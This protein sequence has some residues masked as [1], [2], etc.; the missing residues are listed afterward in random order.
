MTPR[1]ARE[2]RSD[3]AAL[4]AYAARLTQQRRRLASDQRAALLRLG[5]HRHEHDARSALD[6]GDVRCLV[7]AGVL[8]PSG[9]DLD[10]R[11]TITRRAQQ[12]AAL[13]SLIAYTE[14]QARLADHK[15][16][17]TKSA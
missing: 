13:D 16:A 6:A 7:D 4:D 3:G 8:A 14:A 9:A 12:L 1:P 15:E 11:R 5:W 17:V 2:P 10:D